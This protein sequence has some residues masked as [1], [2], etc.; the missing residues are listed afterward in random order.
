MISAMDSWQELKKHTELLKASVGR[1][2]S[3]NINL[4]SLKKKTQEMVQL[5]FRQTRTDLI[6][7]GFLDEALAELDKQM[8]ALL[9]L[10]NGNS[11]RTYYQINLKAV[12]KSHHEIDSQREKIIG[13]INLEKITNQVCLNPTEQKILNVLKQIVPTSAFSFEQACLDLVNVGRISYRGTAN[14]LRESVREL[15]DHLAPDREVVSQKGFKYESGRTTPTMKQKVRFILR[16]RNKPDTA[17]ETPENAVA[18]IDEAVSK[19]TRS[20]Y[21]RSSI[22]THV[23]NSKSEILQMKMYVEGILA[24]LLE[25]HSKP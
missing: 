3:V 2:K 12:I 22:S 17:I 5:F 15:L 8:Q 10:S 6:A 16:A 9:K 1:S 14:E 7:M 23:T 20:V 19:L 18:R 4:V 24:E 13:K 11:R 21:D 25:I